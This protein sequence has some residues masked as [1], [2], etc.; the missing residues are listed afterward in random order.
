MYDSRDIER[1]KNFLSFWTWRY[2]HFTEV[3]YKWQWFLRYEAQQTD[4]ILA[5]L[6]IFCPFNPIAAQ[7]MKYQPKKKKRKKRL[8]ISS[9]YTGVPKTMIIDYTVPEICCMID[10]IVI[11]H[12]G[13][14]L[15]QT[16][17]KMKIKKKKNGK[18]AWDIII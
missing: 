7:K 1:D 17:Q 13:Q 16:A 14:F 6:A 3:Y 18:N 12:L 5:F 11:F 8:E 15:A 10:V 2:H 4:F 9:F